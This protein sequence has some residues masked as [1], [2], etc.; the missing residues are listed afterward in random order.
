MRTLMRQYFFVHQTHLAKTVS[1]FSLIYLDYCARSV[2]VHICSCLNVVQ[3]GNV[4]LCVEL[5]GST[6]LLL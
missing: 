4:E 3:Q 5:I 6:L 1:L 2:H